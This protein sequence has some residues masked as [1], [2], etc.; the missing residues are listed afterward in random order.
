[1][2]SSC[3]SFTGQEDMASLTA[4]CVFPVELVMESHSTHVHTHVHEYDALASQQ[5]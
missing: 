3:Q 5:V 1:M 4:R 2:S